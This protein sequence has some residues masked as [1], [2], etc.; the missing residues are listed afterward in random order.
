MRPKI[1]TSEANS[2]DPFIDET[3]ILTRARMGGV[4][5]PAGER[6]ILD[7]FTTPLEPCQEAPASIRHDFEL[8]W[9]IGL[10]LD[11]HRPRSQL[12]AGDK[13]AY[14]NLHQIAASQFAVDRKIEKRAVS[15]SM[16]AI[17]MK[18]NCPYLSWF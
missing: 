6:K 3:R 18:A 16:L 9:S 11:H 17:Q 1:F 14:L 4:V 5:D 7:R 8:N 12:T 15:K 10:L 2:R 13:V